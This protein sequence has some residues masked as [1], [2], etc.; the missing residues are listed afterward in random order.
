MHI[1]KA[2]VLAGRT[3]GD[4]PWPSVRSI[5]KPLVPVAN[6]PILFHHLDALRHAGVLEARIAVDAGTAG[7]IRRAVGAGEDWGV[8]VDYAEAPAHLGLQDTFAMT[9]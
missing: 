7:A 9:R 4:R 2:L 3:V 5:P 8:R 6:R 1:A